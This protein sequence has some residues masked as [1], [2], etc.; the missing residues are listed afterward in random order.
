MSSAADDQLLDRVGVR[1]RGVEDDDALFAAPVDRDIVDSRACPRDR[2]Q[3]FGQLHLM[4]RGRAHQDAVGV[5]H[6]VADAVFVAVK[7][8]QPVGAD[9]IERFN[10][11]HQP[12]SFSN[13]AISATSFS[14]PSTGIAL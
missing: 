12:F 8:V 14:T 11:V 5:L 13:F 10:V 4:H 1:A 6:V 2:E 9:L 7:D 3:G